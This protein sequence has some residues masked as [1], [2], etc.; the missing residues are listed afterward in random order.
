MCAFYG[1][2]LFDKLPINGIGTDLVVKEVVVVVCGEVIIRILLNKNLQQIVQFHFVIR[3]TLKY[4]FTFTEIAQ[5]KY[6]SVLIMLRVGDGVN[7]AIN[8]MKIFSM[9]MRNITQRKM[10]APKAN[11]P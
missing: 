11:K 3:Q 2:R 9:Q 7:D 4:S 10:R 8:F 6:D 1:I 5:L